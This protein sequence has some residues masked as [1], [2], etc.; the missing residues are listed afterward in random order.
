MAQLDRSI[1]LASR[2]PRRRELLAQIGVRFQL[3]LFRDRPHTDPE[4]DETVLSGETPAAYV[5]RLARAK[6]QA[7]WQRIEQRSLPRAAVLA[8]DTTVALEGRVLGKP[9]D[10]REAAEMLAALSGRRHEVLSAVA[11]THDSK[12]ECAVSVSQVDFKPLSAEEIRRYVATGE[13]DDKAGGYAIQGRAAQFVRELR[14]SF[15]GVMGLPLYETAQL[16]E[17]MGAERER[18]NPR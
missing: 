15:S 1:Y 12:M 10:R 16:L 4:L 6:A 8:A 13:C 17:R 18:R 9:G 3:L 14:G 7:G 5:E 2:S 11:L